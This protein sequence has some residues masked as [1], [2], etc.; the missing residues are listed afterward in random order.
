VIRFFLLLIFPKEN[1][2][3][4]ARNGSGQKRKIDLMGVPLGGNRSF[5][6]SL[7]GCLRGLP[8]SS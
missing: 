3:K 2:K 8:T 7:G 5:N 6:F 4:K 1:R